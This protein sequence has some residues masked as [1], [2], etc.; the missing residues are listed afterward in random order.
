ML[1]EKQREILTKI[2]DDNDNGEGCFEYDINDPDCIELTEMG[3][4]DFYDGWNISIEGIDELDKE[5]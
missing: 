4:I 5:I 2:S 3:Y 1:T